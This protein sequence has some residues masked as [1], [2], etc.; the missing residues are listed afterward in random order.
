M[1]H[2]KLYRNFIILQED[3]RG[4]SSSK[5]KALSG[6]AKV[7]AKGDKC[8]ISFYAQNLKQEDDYSMVL[9]CCKKDSKQLIN[10]GTLKV[11]EAGKGDTSKEYYVNNIA[12]IGISYEK[13]SGAAICRISGDEVTAIMHGFMNGEEITENWRKYKIVDASSTDN[14]ISKEE[15]TENKIT[16]KKVDNLVKE[17]PK[18]IVKEE[19][20]LPKNDNNIVN[21]EIV[22][23]TIEKPI[24]KKQ[25]KLDLDITTN[26]EKFDLERHKDKCSMEESIKKIADKLDTYECDVDLDIRH[27]SDDVIVYGF[28]KNKSDKC[29]NWKKFIINKKCDRS[30]L[31]VVQNHRRLEENM[32]L[33]KM[34]FETYENS[35]SKKSK[36]DFSITG[37][38]GKYFEGIAKG[39]ENYNEK[40]EDISYCKWYKVNVNSMEDLCNKSDY[41]KYTL[42]YYPMINYYP[43]ISKENHFLLGYKCNK[44][45]E[46]KYIIYAI[47]G[48][49]DKT[50]QPYGGKTGFVTWTSNNSRKDGYWLMFYDYKKSSIVVPVK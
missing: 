40:L 29:D 1:A 31:E 34:D 38:E 26:E 42:A 47:P 6:Y 46:L 21:A 2:S 8:K 25:D 22:K 18:K 30:E 39:F 19:S 33:D 17:A 4:Y 3:E 9:I 7:E 37:S 36:D 11:D 41:D 50:D 24:V 45:G 20:T 12:G 28:V 43:Y 35:I 27:L 10:L 32:N 5:D 44:E 16:A 15:F 48:S 49:K 14:E 23:Q 13:I